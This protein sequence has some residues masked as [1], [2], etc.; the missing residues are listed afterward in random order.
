MK[1]RINRR[2]SFLAMLYKDFKLFFSAA[3]LF[4]FLIPFIL[5][6]AFMLGGKVLEKGDYFQAFPIAVQDRDR[7]VMS[8]TLVSQMKAVEMFSEVRVLEEEEEPED[9]LK[10]GAAGVLV[11][12]KDYFYAMYRAED[13]PVELFLNR[14]S[15]LSSVLLRSMLGSVLQIVSSSE[16]ST[17]GMYRWLYGEEL[18]AAKLEEMYAA[19]SRSILKY[20]LSRQNVF[21]EPEA[22]GSL[23]T[24]VGGTLLRRILAVVIP[25]VFFGFSLMAVKTLPEERNLGVTD[26]MR[27]IGC[28]AGGAVFSKFLIVLFTTL[29]MMLY[30]FGLL[31]PKSF[32]CAAVFFLLLELSAFAGA[33][34]VCECCGTAA[35][36]QRAGVLILAA[37]VLLSGKLWPCSFHGALPER[38]GRLTLPFLSYAML[39]AAHSD[40]GWRELFP[41]YITVLAKALI[42]LVL[43]GA[44]MVIRSGKGEKGT[45]AGSGEMIS[46]TETGRVPA[47]PVSSVSRT[48]TLSRLPALTFLKLKNIGG[49]PGWIAV[50]A[51]AAFLLGLFSQVTERKA[52]DAIRIY[53]VDLDRTEASEGLLRELG[54]REGLSV[55]TVPAGTARLQLLTEGAEGLLFIPE[56]F[57]DAVR[58]NG[59]ILLQYQAA[60]GVSTEQSVREMIAGAVTVRRTR[61]DAVMLAEER[62]SRQLSGEELR[63]LDDSIGR[64]RKELPPPL[65]VYEAGGA[66]PKDPFVPDRITFVWFLV[67]MLGLLLADFS[68]SGEA[69]QISFRMRSLPGGR[70]LSSLSDIFTL[71][72]ACFVPGFTFLAGAGLIYGRIAALLSFSF[73]VSCFGLLIAGCSASEGRI[74]GLA[75]YL[76]ILLCILGGCFLDIGMLAP[77][78]AWVVRLSPVGAAQAAENGSAAGYAVLICGGIL[79]GLISMKRGS[80][81]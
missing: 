54:E 4:T 63:A 58:E 29:P 35:L 55:E 16:A 10:E 27:A 22:E 38:L 53:A 28:G 18:T 70:L 40:L 73:F 20:A 44:A 12:P 69:R 59:D 11:I 62:L 39:E 36:T 75:C 66:A 78:T 74:D 48:R 68:S 26:R 56:G 45:E 47:G 60:S 15:G 41:L 79:C 7:T 52:G 42:L 57:Q 46:E 51:A 67:L 31:P 65:R 34:L 6:G 13:S 33:W 9:V 25:I 32:G 21:T 5:T 76:S 64:M 49:Y 50:L 3:G 2:A 14:E 72:S 24:S 61:E 81:D 17:W 23:I 71:A 77:E 80:A 43:A 19:S 30:M 37:S 8:R 1:G